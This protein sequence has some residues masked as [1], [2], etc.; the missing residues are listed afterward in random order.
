M[1]RE[2]DYKRQLI[3][4]ARQLAGAAFYERQAKRAKVKDPNAFDPDAFKGSDVVFGDIQ[5]KKGE[6]R[7]VEK[8]PLVEQFRRDHEN[9]IGKTALTLLLCLFSFCAF[10]QNR[11][12][13]LNVSTKYVEFTWGN[14][15]LNNVEF[16]PFFIALDY[17]EPTAIRMASELTNSLM[18]RPTAI[19]EISADMERT[20]FGV[21]FD[22][23]ACFFHLREY[24]AKVI[25]E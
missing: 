5:R 2:N 18:M 25:R 21:T 22:E 12:T 16:T 23:Y 6:G 10:G 11:V 20:L 8:F 17:A 7:T 9:I 1:K 13:L 19:A 24:R 15:T 14:D 3:E 4:K